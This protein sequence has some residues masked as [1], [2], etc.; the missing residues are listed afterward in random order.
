MKKVVV[1]AAAL[2]SSLL[3]GCA[4]QA[5]GN[6]P[7]A[8]ESPESSESA[9][10]PEHAYCESFTGSMQNYADVLSEITSDQPLDSAKWTTLNSQ[11]DELNLLN[12]DALPMGW[13]F[14]HF[15][16]VSAFEQIKAALAGDGTL[17]LTT[18]DWKTGSVSLIERCVE[19]GFKVS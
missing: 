17:T 10:S 7:A 11:I 18:T 19:T 6:S 3:V 5:E 9:L 8:E 15:D 2:F 12:V 13:S 16:Y 4:P 1:V 14:D